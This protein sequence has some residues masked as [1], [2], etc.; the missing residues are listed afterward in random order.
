MPLKCDS[1]GKNL[2]LSPIRPSQVYVTAM[3]RQ[4]GGSIQKRE[5]WVSEILPSSLGSWGWQHR[6]G[7]AGEGEKKET[8]NWP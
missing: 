8:H 5:T 6:K 4:T 2:E 1:G 7:E 3:S